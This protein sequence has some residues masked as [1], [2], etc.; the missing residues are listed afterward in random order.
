[1][2]LRLRLLH[3]VTSGLSNGLSKTCALQ[4]WWGSEASGL[5]ILEIAGRTTT[6][7]QPHVGAICTQK[8]Y[9]FHIPMPAV[10]S[11]YTKCLPSTEVK[12]ESEI[13]LHP[14]SARTA[15]LAPWASTF[16]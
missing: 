3:G 5:L 9:C 14:A 13:L 2:D 10:P 4:D 11:D 6:T 12:K 15:R 7:E 8:D 1:M 16:S